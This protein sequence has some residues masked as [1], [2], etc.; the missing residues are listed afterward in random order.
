MSGQLTV[1]DTGPIVAALDR[2]DHYHH[3]CAQLIATTPRWHNSTISALNSGVNER[4]GRDFFLAMVSM[5]GHP[6]RA[7]P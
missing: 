3:A 2:S 5:I 7:N 4:R 1:F 6:S